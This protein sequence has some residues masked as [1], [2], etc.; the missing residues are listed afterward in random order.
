MMLSPVPVACVSLPDDRLRIWAKTAFETIEISV[1]DSYL[2][3]P[4]LRCPDAMVSALQPV[5]CRS[6]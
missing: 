3:L 2:V 5:I 6:I 1:Q 4:R